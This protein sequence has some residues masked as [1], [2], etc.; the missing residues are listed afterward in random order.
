MFNCSQPLLLLLL[1][2]CCSGPNLAKIGVSTKIKRACPEQS[3]PSVRTVGAARALCRVLQG[4]HVHAASRKQRGPVD[5][6]ASRRGARSS[7]CSKRPSR[8]WR[9][10]A[11]PAR[12][13]QHST[14]ISSCRVRRARSTHGASSRIISCAQLLL[15]ADPAELLDG[16]EHQVAPLRMRIL[17]AAALPW[18][19][20]AA[21]RRVSVSA[22]AND[23]SSAA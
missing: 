7:V 20:S 21:V 10:G 16:K 12:R 19:S 18:S 14:R 3:P 4:D 22:K 13:A 15:Y 11:L 23:L 6:D 9:A 8:P 1:F 5:S 17:A 2:N